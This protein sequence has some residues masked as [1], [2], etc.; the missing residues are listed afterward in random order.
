MHKSITVLAFVYHI[1]QV[2]ENTLL[3]CDLVNDENDW[4]VVRF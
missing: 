4:L 1:G 3:K 2:A